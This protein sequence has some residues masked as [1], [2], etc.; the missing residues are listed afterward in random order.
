MFAEG[1]VVDLRASIE[2][3]DSSVRLVDNLDDPNLDLHPSC[4][5]GSFPQKKRG[6]RILL[7]PRNYLVAGVGFEPTTFGL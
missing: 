3:A 5:L 1:E 4:T 2:G 6:R 7:T